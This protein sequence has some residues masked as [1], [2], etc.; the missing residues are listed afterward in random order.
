M[1]EKE[2]KEKL[3]NKL[4]EYRNSLNLPSDVTF[5]IE[6]EYENIPNLNVSHLLDKIKKDTNKCNDWVNKKE[7]S[8]Q[9]KNRFDERM[10][11]EINSPILNDSINNWQDLK[12]I[13][14]LLKQKN[15]LITKKCG[16]HV[17]VGLHVLENKDE[18]YRNLLLLWIL[19]EKEIYSFSSGEYSNVR[20]NIDS[21]ITNIS[22]D[23]NL[24]DII[25]I[26]NCNYLLKFEKLLFD[27]EHDLYI[28]P[29]QSKE[30]YYN[31]RIEF[32]VPNGSL[33]EEIWQ[34]YIN[35]FTKFVIACKKEL[36]VEKTLYKIKNN[37][38]TALELANYIFD[39]NIDKEYFL[40]QALK[41]NKIYKK[42]LPEH[43]YYYN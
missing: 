19:Y 5:G 41:T 18:Y 16:G 27:K 1:T 32:R 36:D 14:N 37:Q 25:K 42:E 39:D 22:Y 8:I 33:S 6:I 28:F 11:G 2:Y 21:Y 35:F 15:G 26:E 38:H 34:N 31:N 20:A 13:L 29:I 10:N 17:N 7:L 23:I 30:I 24:N 3:K 40:I 43:K 4:I 9:E 12:I